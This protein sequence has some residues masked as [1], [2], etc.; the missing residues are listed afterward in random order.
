MFPVALGT[1]VQLLDSVEVE[2]KRQASLNVPYRE[3]IIR[4]TKTG[5]VSDFTLRKLLSRLSPDM[6]PPKV[7]PSF[8]FW[9]RNFYPG[10]KKMP[11]KPE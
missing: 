3:R 5:I 10:K 8:Q 11:T 4:Y 2:A 1:S 6:E 7:P 9:H